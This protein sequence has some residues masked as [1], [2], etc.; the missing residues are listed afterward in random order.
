[1]FVDSQPYRMVY[2]RK[3]LT[4]TF[5]CMRKSVI[6]ILA[7]Y[8]SFSPTMLAPV[9]AVGNVL[10]LYVSPNGNDANACTNV[11]A[12][13]RTI[14][15]AS[16]I[17]D[18]SQSAISQ[19]IIHLEPGTYVEQ[20]TYF[21]KN[22]S[23][24]GTDYQNT[25][26]D[27]IFGVSQPGVSLT[28]F[29]LTLQGNGTLTVN[30][31]T[32]VSIVESRLADKYVI[33]NEGGTVHF[34][35]SII[36]DDIT[37]NNG[38]S[39]TPNPPISTM[40]LDRVTVSGINKI[41][42]SAYAAVQET[43]YNAQEGVLLI[44]DSII[45]GNTNIRILNRGNL[46][47]ERTNIDNNISEDP[48]IDSQSGMIGFLP[49]TIIVD[50]SISNNEIVNAGATGTSIIE[51]IGEMILSDSVVSYNRNVHPG[52]LGAGAIDSA[53][54]SI[55]T[56]ER[57]RFV[58]NYGVLGGAISVRAAKRLTITD[59]VFDANVG[60]SGGALYL[61]NMDRGLI[62]N[63]SF[64]DNQAMH[65]AAL[66]HSTG[67]ALYILNDDA[68]SKIPVTRV[69]LNQVTVAN[70]SAGTIGGGVST[71]GAV[72]VTMRNVTIAN[73]ML[74]TG[75]ITPSTGGAGLALGIRGI[76][77]IRNS[78]IG[79]NVFNSTG[80]L[81]DCVIQG[82]VSSTAYNLDSDTS[83]GF[84]GLGDFSGVN[85]QLDPLRNNGGLTDTMA[86]LGGPAVDGGDPN[87]CEGLDVDGFPTLLLDDQRGNGFSRFVDAG[88]GTARCDMGAYEAHDKV[89]SGD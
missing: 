60:E 56:V 51:N 79:Q 2:I 45:A 69:A 29:G 86:L 27:G 35:D 37:I 61:E 15:R 11:A 8:L 76:L 54:D 6:V 18:N 43:F 58:G 20:I 89:Y 44:S 52:T 65:M 80:G 33:S 19:G 12:P 66:P 71:N 64:S 87:G 36:T 13:C 16:D 53:V 17:I 9:S 7:F 22:T 59:S 63:S 50:S 83:C 26:V 85:P 28:V 57:S 81:S 42:N 3:F 77:N 40:T 78:I 30:P 62:E 47:I 49:K 32:I 4:Y 73:N 5:H 24:V 46:L 34:T 55:L 39:H 31:S 88:S 74:T 25:F 67:G 68:V 1:M 21:A 41:P 82:V 23:I 48:I 38:W 84:Y 75:I 72:F 70:N 14:Y 10:D